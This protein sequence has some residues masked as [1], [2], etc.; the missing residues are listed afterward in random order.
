[1]LP[2]PI[3][4][5][6]GYLCPGCGIQR[7]FF[8]LIELDFK[9]SFSFYPPLLLGIFFTFLFFVLKK[10]FEKLNINHLIYINLFV[11]LVNFLSKIL[12]DF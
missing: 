12:W 8:C 9:E 7:S 10:W 3:R 11:V 2:C 5:C 1:M 6:T 4:F